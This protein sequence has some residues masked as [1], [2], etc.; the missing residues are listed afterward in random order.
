M[1]I[2]FTKIIQNKQEISN[3][4][5]ATSNKQQATSNKQ[6][7]TNNYTMAFVSTGTYTTGPITVTF[8]Q[9]ISIKDSRDLLNAII[10]D[11]KKKPKKGD[12]PKRAPTD[13]N[14]FMK[15]T[16][17]E[18]KTEELLTKDTF[19]KQDNMDR[20]AK[21]SQMWKAEKQDIIIDTTI[22][23]DKEELKEQK[24]KEKEELKEQK[25]KEKEE[26]KQQKKKEKEEL[27][28][29]KQQ[30]KEKDEDEDEDE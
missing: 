24:K 4:Q 12:K 26:L 30:K 17:D 15:K 27:K 16:L 3:K 13:Y 21:A 28:Q 18:L 6:Q 23:N 20:F 5:Q 22:K 11:I 9:D 19:T 10:S 8:T 1:I 25:K 7:T 29:L 2:V 14:I